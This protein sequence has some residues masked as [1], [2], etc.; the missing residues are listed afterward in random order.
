MLCR[1]LSSVFSGR[2]TDCCLVGVVRVAAGAFLSAPQ[3][4]VTHVIACQHRSVTSTCRLP[5]LQCY[6]DLVPPVPSRG[7]IVRRVVSIWRDRWQSLSRVTSVHTHLFQNF[8]QCV[9]YLVKLS[10]PLWS[11]NSPS[12]VF[13]SPFQS[14]TRWSGC[15]NNNDNRA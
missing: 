7:S 13:W 11:S 10:C 15:N 9:L 5:S 4:A 1:F 2:S 14:Q 8:F 3:T 12:A 6:L